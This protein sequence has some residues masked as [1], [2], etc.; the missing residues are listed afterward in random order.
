MARSL[1]NQRAGSWASATLGNIVVRTD[2][3]SSLGPFRVF[4]DY[5]TTYP[6]VVIKALGNLYEEY[7]RAFTPLVAKNREWETDYQR[8]MLGG[9]PINWC[10]QIDM[11]GLPEAFLW[12]IVEMSEEVVRE[13]LRKGIFEIENSIAVYQLLENFFSR[14]GQDSFFKI[15]FRTVLDDLRRRFARPIALLAV[16]DEKYHSMKE[17]EFGKRYREQLAKAEVFDLSGFDQLF[18]P[19]EFRQY[20][21]ENGDACEYLLYA[22][23]SDPVSKLKY[24]ESSVAHPLLSDSRIRRLIRENALTLNVDAPEMKYPNRIND[25]KEYM[26]P[27]G[28]AF[29][30]VAMEDLRSS[31]FKTY[32]RAQGFDTP[33]AAML[34]CKPAKGA[35][36]CYGHVVRVTIDGK[37]ALARGLSLW[38]D[39]VV[40]PEMRT[41][42]IVNTTDG[43]A[44]TFIDRNF[45]GLVDGHPKFLGGVRNLMPVESIEAREGRIHGNSSAVYAEIVC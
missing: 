44:Y 33:A 18:S 35:Y 31:A 9:A 17:S 27:M 15:R 45:F 26:P 28:M 37:K 8:C 20:V 1:L 36:G 6:E 30:I 2:I 23:T 34:R 24:P 42:V 3:R 41:P 25:T 14:N 40:Q 13:I 22:R 11:V 21:R 12:E 19:S 29:Q 43:V 5:R 4:L 16:T 32:L 38:G 10:V 39:Y 7:N